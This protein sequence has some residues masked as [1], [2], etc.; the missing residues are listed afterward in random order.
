MSDDNFQKLDAF[1]TRNVPGMQNTVS[2]KINPQKKIGALQ[3]VFAIGLSCIIGYTIID[4]ENKKLE[5]A[6]ALSEELAWD[7]T[8]DEDLLLEVDTLAD[9]D[10]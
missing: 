10:I 5:S 9:I 7:P 4:R 1:M 2:R 6:S 8:S 3:Y